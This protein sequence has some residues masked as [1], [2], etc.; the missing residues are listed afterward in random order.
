MANYLLLGAGFSRNW[1]GW[2]ASEAFEYLLGCDEIIENQYL[3][4]LLWRHQSNGGF[5]NALAELQSQRNADPAT[6]DDLLMRLQNAVT[7]MFD[8]M[9]KGF[10]RITDWEPSK[11]VDRKIS[12]F[13]SRFDA[14]FTL[15]QDVFLEHFYVKNFPLTG[16]LKWSGPHLP[17]MRHN[18]YQSDDPR[19]NGSWA[20][21]TWYPSENVS[22]FQ[23]E[24]GCQPIFKLHG[25]SNWRNR[26]NDP[27][28]IM[29]G[30]K[31]N[32]ISKIPILKWYAQE[33][34][35]R[36]QADSSRLM[37]IGY[38]FR[39]DHINTAISKAVEKGLK[40]FVIAPDGA[41]MAHRLNP[42][43]SPGQIMMR[44]AL[45]DWLEVALV[46]A[47]RRQLSEIFSDDSIEFDK[48]MRFFES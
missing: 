5:E 27:M 9:N 10:M 28:L 17:G 22:D 29:G 25:S 26:G 42:T 37:V 1:G 11:S 33:F 31:A 8:D 36:L 43:R 35:S 47:S 13:L 3:K 12:P 24:R 44:T 15:N 40:L 48:V 2:L 18:A 32:E 39:D 4:T 19:M 45:E 16:P 34:D 23:V 30:G 46:G 14:I 7:Q 6:Y 38:G 21:P 20:L 41:E